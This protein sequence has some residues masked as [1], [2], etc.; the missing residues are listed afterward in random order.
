MLDSYE[1][2][3]GTAYNQSLPSLGDVIGDVIQFFGCERVYGVGGDFAANLIA[4]IAP[5]VAVCPSSNEM[6]AGFSACAKA[7]I[8]GIGFCL[9]TYMVGS[10][11]CTSAAALAVTEGLP[12]VF[13][14]GAPAE[15]EVAQMAIH[16]T[17]HPSTA[18]KTQYDNALDAFAALG[19][20]VE[21]LQ[22]QRTP[23][24]PN[25]SGERFYQLVLQAYK[26]K[27]PVFIEIPRDQVIQKTQAI[28]LPISID[29]PC[30]CQHV[31]SGAELVVDAIVTKLASAQYPLLYIG[32][33]LKH[34]RQLQQLLLNF[35]RKFNIPFATSWFA[36]GLFDESEPLCLGAY[37]GIFSQ[38]SGRLYIEEKV[39]YIIDI[40]S[41]IVPQDSNIAFATGT[42]KVE[43]FAN[44]TLL[45]GG[46]LLEKDL[47]E[48][49]QLLMQRQQKVFNF[50]APSAAK[51]TLNL[52]D[53]L[54]FNNLA[55]T[56]NHIQRRI[57]TQLVYLPEVGNS[58]FAS[59]SLQVRQSSVGRGWLTNPWYGAMGTAL[60]YARVVAQR[61]QDNGED[62]RAVVIIG[63]G[64]FHFQ[65][66]EL[67]HF[68]KDNTDV[69]II[70]MRNNVFHLGKSGDQAIYHCNDQRFDVAALMRS[71][72]GYAHTVA[73]VAEFISAFKATL[74]RSGIS[75]LEVP[76]QPTDERQCHEIRLLNLYIK[77]KN[78]HPQA[79]Q[80]WQALTN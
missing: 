8:D 38:T 15:T 49:L 28:K 77:A 24:Y 12:V 27:Q 59:Y 4:A 31:L 46:A 62:E 61:L 9:T 23:G 1:M 19:V 71:Y 41:S 53:P 63:D 35:A 14:S 48:I 76:A 42:H 50:S 72:Q 52:Q 45:K 58:Y 5:R 55:Q 69:T 54:D 17:L 3:L 51:S 11:P 6:H 13:I 7:E 26:T 75:L 25:V 43:T 64:G 32:D 70:Y 78:G 47:L 18:W 39:D 20:K 34:N 73:S 79:Q 22:G 67:I 60:P 68:L 80:E 66:N 65:L 36:K 37:N 29:A 2:N 57:S 16:H 56:L 44:K 21:R 10:L 30:I 74:S 40:A 33:R